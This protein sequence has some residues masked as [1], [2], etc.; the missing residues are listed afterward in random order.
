ME[1][2]TG[3][4]GPRQTVGGMK[5]GKRGGTGGGGRRCNGPKRRKEL[6]YH[7]ATSITRRDCSELSEKLEG[8][9][10]ECALGGGA[11][12]FLVSVD[13]DEVEGEDVVLGPH[14]QPP[15]LLIQQESVVARAVGQAVEGDEVT[16]L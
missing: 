11:Y 13:V 15:P 16:R 9:R 4:S 7:F 3:L 10:A 2:R 5:E 1:L 8:K 12:L 6:K 14:Q